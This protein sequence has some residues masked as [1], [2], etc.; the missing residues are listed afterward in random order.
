MSS[1][2]LRQAI[3]EPAQRNAWNFEP[4]LVEL[5]LRDIKGQ[6]GSLP[7]LS[8]ALLETWRRRRGRI[9]TLAGYAESGGVQGAIAHT[10]DM[11][12]QQ[13]L[14]ESQQAIARHI[15]LRLTELGE[16]TPE[17]RRRAQISELLPS[18]EQRA[19]VEEVL[20]K[21]V[22]ARLLTISEN[23]VEISH[24]ALIR[25]WPTLRQW[26][27]EDRQSIKLHRQLTQAARAWESMERDESVLFRGARLAETLEWA[28][29]HNRELN[30]L[31][32]EFLE[33]SRDLAD[34]R[35]QAQDEQRQRELQAA[36][37][38][39]QSEQ[40][41]VIEQ[42]RANRRL[43]WLLAGLAAVLLVAVFSAVYAFNQRTIAQNETRLATSRQLAA[44]A[45]NNLDADPQLSILLALEAVAEA[46][47]AGLPVPR[48]AQE[49]LHQ[50]LQASRLEMVINAHPGGVSALDFSPDGQ[51][52]VSVGEDRSLKTWDT[53]SG[54]NLETTSASDKRIAHV[55]YSPDG[56]YLA[57]ADHDQ[58]AKVWD[59]KTLAK[60][61]TIKGHDSGLLAL[62]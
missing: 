34:R 55:A 5:I 47:T 54:M 23:Y 2:E 30:T 61:S 62:A 28:G 15:F 20:E 13:G 21:L 58:T 40:Q 6:P 25:E 10:A 31:E 22:A 51:T 48:E 26:L 18:A 32:R 57:T 1:D 9:L 4:G 49:A 29:E 45:V 17:I 53:T 43:R 56:D 36:Q 14:D 12:Y 39:A 59:S 38:L 46:R 60:I 33:V 8:H 3:E 41:R 24:E 16:D 50:S 19:A 7:L 27:E 42:T 52:L 44:A 37:Q 11:V 35:R